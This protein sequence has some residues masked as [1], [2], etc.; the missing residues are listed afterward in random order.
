MEDALNRKDRFAACVWAA[1]F[2]E[3]LLEDVLVRLGVEPEGRDG[4]GRPELGGMID[5]VRKRID[6]D[7]ALRRTGAEVVDCAHGVRSIRNRLVH[8]TG[9]AKRDLDSA[10]RRI[11]DDLRV[12]LAWWSDLPREPQSLQPEIGRVFLSTISPDQPRHRGFLADIE[13]ALKSK[14]FAVV[15]L[16]LS[17]YDRRVPLTRA[18]EFIRACDVVL[19]IGLERSH[20]YYVRDREGSEKETSI[21]DRL[22]SSAWLH[23]EA[24]LAHGL[25]KP[26]F[27]LC[28]AAIADEGVFDRNWNEFPVIEMATLSVGNQGVQ[29]A[30][31]RIEG[32]IRGRPTTA[33]T[34]S[35]P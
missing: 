25:G 7:P 15:R 35:L 6:S 22:Y 16:F 12:I 9:R 24:G 28:E 5:K 13:R 27:V 23:M 1:V 14:G 2:L 8:N 31:K 3:A 33:P 34:E 21:T 4:G 19:C 30:L 18:A 20:A 11:V 29:E 17:E 32:Y 10:A 26:V